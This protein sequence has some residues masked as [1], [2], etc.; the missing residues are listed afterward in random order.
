MLKYISVDPRIR[1][2]PADLLES[3]VV[4]R[5]NRFNEE[6]AE[7]F[8]ENLSKAHETGQ[9]IVPIVIDSY[10]GHVYSLLSMITEVQNSK[11]P[12]AT[13]I[14]SKAFSCGSILFSCGSE[15]YRYCAPNATLM[16]HEVGGDSFGKVEDLKVDAEEA[17]RLNSLLF[18]VLAKNCGKPEDF[19][20]DLIHEKGHTDYFLTAKEAKKLNLANHLRV[21]EFRIN[22]TVDIKLH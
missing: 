19:F 10:G 21:P 20:L 1:I 3:P 13:V 6:S 8:S 18:K 22:V 16:I 11:I 15:G 14:E 12:V 5:V 7:K 4:I 17:D 9:P 2:K